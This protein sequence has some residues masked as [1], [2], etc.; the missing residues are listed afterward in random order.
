MAA[1]VR[2]A[3]T[4]WGVAL[5]LALGCVA[6]QTACAIGVLGGVREGGLTKGVGR[7]RGKSSGGDG[8]MRDVDEAVVIDFL[9]RAHNTSAIGSEDGLPSWRGGMGRAPQHA[10]LVFLLYSASCAF[11]RD[12][13]ERVSA[14][15]E[16]P[17]YADRFAFV[18]M[19]KRAA[20]LSFLMRNEFHAVPQIVVAS[21]AG[22]ARLRGSDDA[23]HVSSR[24]DAVLDHPNVTCAR[25]ALPLPAPQEQRAE[26]GEAIVW[27][28][29]RDEATAWAAGA[30]V[31]M[32]A[33]AI[34][35]RAWERLRPWTS[36]D[37]HAH[38]D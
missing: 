21:P 18:S 22:L 4:R 27:H 38:E 11:S 3:L 25:H 8:G 34:G 30:V 15:S 17:R 5:A 20:S 1:S 24:L 10:C 23:D 14:L 36:G 13:Y 35:M 32:A 29:A 6:L 16:D 2:H 37:G 12:S 33:A 26:G 31:C 19:D 28:D 9:R 7:T